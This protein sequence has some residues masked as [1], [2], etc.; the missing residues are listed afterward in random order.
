MKRLHLCVL[1]LLPVVAAAARAEE[2]IV[3]PPPEFATVRNITPSGEIVCDYIDWKMVYETKTRNILENNRVRTEQ[4][5]VPRKVA[6]RRVM[7]CA[8][9]AY[10]ILNLKG[11]PLRMN[12]VG[13]R[14]GKG[15]PI[16]ILPDS[17]KLD[18]YYRQFL[19]DDVLVLVSS[20]PQL[21][22][23]AAPRIEAGVPQPMP[24]MPMPRP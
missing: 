11:E 8:L 10:E 22:V 5:T 1:G 14:L 4:Y 18:D 20:D 15:T 2:K 21:P 17:H 19:K 13:K 7:H 3:S 24:P 12:D 23:K 6:E 9:G 16:L